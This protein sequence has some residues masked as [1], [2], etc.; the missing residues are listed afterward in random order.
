M[1]AQR[2]EPMWYQKEDVQLLI[3]NE[4]AALFNEMGLGKTTTIL[5]TFRILKA[6]GVVKNMLVCT[7]EKIANVTWPNE[8]RK[9]E[10]FKDLSF[11]SLHGPYKE[12]FA[13]RP[14]IDIFL[15]PFD[16]LLWLPAIREQFDMVVVDESSKIKDRKAF[17]TRA[18]CFF[19]ERAKRRY[20]MSGTPNGQNVIEDLFTQYLFLDGGNALGKNYGAFH[21]RFMEGSG[22]NS[23]PKKGAEERVRALTGHFTRSR[24]KASVGIELPPLTERTIRVDIGGAARVEY[25]EMQNKL[26]AIVAGEEIIAA[27]AAVKAG[28][29]KQMANGAAYVYADTDERLTGRLHEAKALAAKEYVAQ[30]NASGRS[31]LICYEYYHDLEALRGILPG[32]QWIGGGTD[33]ALQISADWNAGKLPYL[34]IH[35]KSGAYGLNLQEVAG[36]VLF[37]SNPW[38]TEDTLQLIARLH[39]TGQKWPVEVCRLIASGTIDEEIY[40]RVLGHK[41][42]MIDFL[43]LFQS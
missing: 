27:N 1:T 7:L 29:L 8:I 3:T 24:T 16:S 28:V 6:A 34:A 19:G 33:D 38:S 35:P 36:N 32:L 30:S 4:Y 11:V 20:A 39:R 22:R 31:V 18:C 25:K 40:S 14:D 13:R 2:W 5:E 12:D 42:G 37:Y 21:G 9:W 26:A 23:Q 17:R 41:T 15:C 10:Q 43:S